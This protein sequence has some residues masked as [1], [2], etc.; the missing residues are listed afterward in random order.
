MTDKKPGKKPAIKE[1]RYSSNKDVV[2]K[3]IKGLL[4]DN[5]RKFNQEQLDLGGVLTVLVGKNGT[6]KSTLLGMVGEVFRSS[7]KDIHDTL[8]KVSMLVNKFQIIITQK[9]LTNTYII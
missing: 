5:F 9:K 6:M 7:E 2:I 4:I 1:Y 3:K 8:L